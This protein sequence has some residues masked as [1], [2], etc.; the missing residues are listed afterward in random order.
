[1]KVFNIAEGQSHKFLCAMNN[2]LIL[3]AM[4]KINAAVQ[5]PGK[6]S[7]LVNPKDFSNCQR[8]KILDY[9]DSN[10]RTISSWQRTSRFNVLIEYI[11]RIKFH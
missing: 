6:K 4:Y 5:M 11:P 3:T 8:R 7:L 10:E 2:L 1:M 9:F